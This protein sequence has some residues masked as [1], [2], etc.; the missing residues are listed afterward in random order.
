MKIIA[1]AEYLRRHGRIDWRNF[2]NRE[3]LKMPRITR[4][5]RVSDDINS[6]PE[7]WEMRYKIGERSLG[8]WLEFI[9][10]A[11]RNCGALAPMSD[12]GA[13]AV[14]FKCHS[15]PTKVRLVW[16]WAVTHR[17]ILVGPES[18]H[19]SESSWM[20]RNYPYGQGSRETNKSQPGFETFPYKRREEKIREEEIKNKKP[21]HSAVAFEL[22]QWLEK[23]TWD[24]FVEMRKKERHPLTDHAKRLI[25]K[26][27]GDF[28]LNGH[29]PNESL[30]ASITHG[31]RDV[32]EPKR[33]Q[34]KGELS[35]EAQRILKR[36]L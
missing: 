20:L 7:V 26:K 31:W 34:K 9:A 8:I 30:N 13:T 14:A 15:S 21:P 19:G 36:G 25:V 12:S 4:W 24:A 32:Y 35:S 23:L 1:M 18:D 2:E 11:N 10:M 33:E 17:W 3:A 28:M 27:L 6:D 16:D 22:P 29:D 5:F